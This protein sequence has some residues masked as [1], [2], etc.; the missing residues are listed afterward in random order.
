MS[1][2]ASLRQVLRSL[3]RSR[4]FSA[5]VIATLALGIGAN[6]AIFS[7]VNG[8]LLK[9]LP[10]PQASRIAELQENPFPEVG[11]A[12]FAFWRQR[13]TLFED[14]SAHWLDH[15]NLTGGDR[16]EL[17]AAGLASAD[18]FHLY[19]ASVLYGRTF[20]AEEDR[21]GGGHVVVLSERLWRDRYAADPAIVGKSI[22]LGDVPH[23]VIGVLG[24]F[25]TELFDQ[26]PDLWVPF[27]IDPAG[28]TKDGRLCYVTARLRP[29]VTLDA[30]RAQIHVLAQEYE[31]V[32]P[33]G[34]RLRDTSTVQPLIAAV[35]G[36]VRLP[37]LILAGAVGL[38]LLI[39]CANVASLLL[40][41]SAGRSREFA[42]RAALGG[43]RLQIVR[44]LLAETGVLSLAGGALGLGLGLAGVRAFVALYPLQPLGAGA[45]TA[46]LPRIAGPSAIAIDWRVLLFTVAASI[47]TGILFGL[48]P[49]LGVSCA[50]L[51]TALK[52]SGNQSGRGVRNA[53]VRSLLVTGEI[54]L[55]LVLL[56]GAGLLIRTMIALREVKPGFDARN[57]LTMQMSVAEGRRPR[58][59]TPTAFQEN[60]CW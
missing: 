36:E 34:I 35:S 49:A 46:G 40:A 6:S 33:P 37:L 43:T 14:V 51:G 23:T 29:G 9:P 31:R 17:V 55:A 11:S 10:F 3:R 54:A 8:I 12:K 42:I 21:P 28:Q 24:S 15:I 47:L 19:G 56:I 2:L 39:A 44:P 20:T 58:T 45:G 48:F 38:V 4:G 50:D 5:A 52:E 57:V 25:D 26:A 30:A 22:S 41:R 27:Q 18:F 16:P 53:R 1:R 7:L 59:S 32:H 13:S 60:G